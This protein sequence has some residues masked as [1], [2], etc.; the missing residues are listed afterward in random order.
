[1]QVD[2]SMRLVLQTTFHVPAEETAGLFAFLGKQTTAIISS[3]ISPLQFNWISA[4]INQ[5]SRRA[6]EDTDSDLA[7]TQ[8]STGT[9]VISA[10]ESTFAQ[11]P[12][13]VLEDVG[14]EASER[15]E[16]TPPPHKPVYLKITFRICQSQRNPSTTAANFLAFND[17]DAM[18]W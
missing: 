9:P 16:T 7:R 13:A 6:G 4:T 14:Y 18:L 11:S 2:T 8:G 15:H 17:G 10:A 5:Q 12:L 1:M 3:I